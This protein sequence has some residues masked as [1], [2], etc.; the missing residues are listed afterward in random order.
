MG[1]A[2]DFS[3]NGQRTQSNYYTVDG[4]SANISAGN[5]GGTAGAA[6]GGALGGSTALGTT[7]TLLSVDALQ[8]FRVQSSTYSAAYGRSPGGQFSLVES[9]GNE[10]RAGIDL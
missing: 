10:R 9:V 2:G 8:E 7:Q 4:V 6:T 1:T 3:V 5:G